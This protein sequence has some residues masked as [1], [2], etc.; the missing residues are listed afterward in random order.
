MT[1]EVE[2]VPYLVDHP[3]DPSTLY[4]KIALILLLSASMIVTAVSFLRFRIKKKQA[5]YEK[6]IGVLGISNDEA[7]FST[8]AIGEEYA[9]GD[10][11]L[12]VTFA[13]IVCLFGF[14]SLLFGADMVSLNPSKSNMVLTG[15]LTKSSAELQQLRWQSQ[16]VLSMAFLGA[17]IWSMQNIIRR[18]ITGD[19]S[20]STYYSTGLRMIFASLLSLIL[21]FFLE[22]F[23]TAN[24]TREIMPVIAFLTG[25]LPDN[26]LVYLRERISIFSNHNNERCHDLPLQ[27]IEGINIFHK[28][29]LGEVGIDNAQNLAEANVI[30][31]L[32][33]TPFNPNQLIDWIAQAR[34]YIYFKENIEELRKIGI[35][36][37]FDLRTLCDNKDQLNRLTEKVD[38]P[39]WSLEIICRRLR[40]DKGVV[41]LYQFH[42][43]LSTMDGYDRRVGHSNNLQDSQLAKIDSGTK[44]GAGQND[45]QG[46]MDATR[47]ASN[48][49]INLPH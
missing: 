30:E 13:T 23:P 18:L 39:E 20:P 40:A 2:L 4:F 14:S 31:L 33:K 43:S 49:M 12:P 26:V 17:F 41:R 1:N 16:L 36:T 8:R 9:S 45:D 34:L 48:S 10:Y 47:E 15:M 19:L 38:I 25:M 21:S 32:L 44:E 22:V 46:L 29:R 24:Y 11:V 42:N 27:M 6:L 28:V 3:F 35:R 7:E 37:I 5:E